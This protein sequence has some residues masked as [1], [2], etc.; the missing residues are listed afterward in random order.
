[1]EIK[2]QGHKPLSLN[3]YDASR[4]SDSEVIGQFL[5]PLRHG[6]GPIEH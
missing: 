5:E 1:M 4:R 3:F 2:V 6:V